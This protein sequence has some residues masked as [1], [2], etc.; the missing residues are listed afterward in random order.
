MTEIKGKTIKSKD[1]SDLFNKDFPDNHLYSSDLTTLMEY[2]NEVDLT[3]QIF[4]WADEAI[5]ELTRRKDEVEA[6]KSSQEELI[7]LQDDVN[8]QAEQVE[9]QNNRIRRL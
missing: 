6:F 8:K 7:K 5:R 4:I 1:F 9:Q 3:Q 2:E